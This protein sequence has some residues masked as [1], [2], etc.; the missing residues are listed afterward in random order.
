MPA[1]E[2]GHLLELVVV[3]CLAELEAVKLDLKLALVAVIAG[4]RTPVT[5]AMVHAYLATHLGIDGASTNMWHHDPEDFVVR[6]SHREDLELVLCTNVHN[7]PFSLICCPWLQ[8]LLA[9][10]SSFCYS[11]LVGMR[12]VPL[13]VR[14]VV[15]A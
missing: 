3:P 7:E 14:S 6:F 9:S 15:V 2:R 8:T 10:V 5:L 13:H 11:V 1:Q 12:H 4:T